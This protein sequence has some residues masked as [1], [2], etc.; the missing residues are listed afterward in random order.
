MS[1]DQILPGSG[2]NEIK[3]TVMPRQGVPGARKSLLVRRHAFCQNTHRPIAESRGGRGLSPLRSTAPAVM[4]Q[5]YSFLG[6]LISIHRVQLAREEGGSRSARVGQS[7][8]QPCRSGRW[9]PGSRIGTRHRR[10]RRWR[11]Y[12]RIL[13]DVRLPAPWQLSFWTSRQRGI[14][15][16]ETS[17]SWKGL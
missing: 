16:D 5:V 17:A 6:E 12:N 4:S 3:Q 1:F 7:E 13:R 9:P 11:F 2:I 10:G 15:A 8:A 14:D